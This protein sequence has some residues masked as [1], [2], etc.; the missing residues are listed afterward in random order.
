MQKP[1]LSSLPQEQQQE[2]H[3]QQRHSAVQSRFE[4]SRIETSPPHS[5]EKLGL[6]F[7]FE[8]G[9]NAAID[10]RPLSFTRKGKMG[11]YT[12]D[13]VVLDDT[14]LYLFGE[15]DLH[16]NT[17]FNQDSTQAVIRGLPNAV[18][19]RTCSAPSQGYVDEDIRRNSKKIKADFDEL[20][21]KF[22]T[23]KFIKVVVPGDGLGTGEALLHINAKKTYAL[24]K[25]NLTQS[26]ADLLHFSNKELRRLEHAGREFARRMVD[27]EVCLM[28]VSCRDAI[29]AYLVVNIDGS[30]VCVPF[31]I[32]GDDTVRVGEFVSFYM[33]EPEGNRSAKTDGHRRIDENDEIKEFT[34][35]IVLNNAAGRKVCVK[36]ECTNMAY[37]QWY[38]R[39][40]YGRG[41]RAKTSRNVE[42]Q[43]ALQ[44]KQI[45]DRVE[46][47]RSRS[48]LRRHDK[49]ALPSLDPSA[50]AGT[51]SQI[52]Q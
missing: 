7:P 25:K 47:E 40:P 15:N 29:S 16:K 4:E 5:S 32:F 50:I 39:S 18:G 45:R 21:S 52:K 49:T 27:D 3:Q 28:R 2:H 9:F 22:K 37:V 36:V 44:R 24:I 31:E 34:G 12:R 6:N 35:R 14:T 19:I 1:G 10:V 20:L 17:L 26:R 46:S 11:W 23:G 38:N 48:E 30:D 33:C 43:R 8:T 13:S 42:S 41:H 51:W